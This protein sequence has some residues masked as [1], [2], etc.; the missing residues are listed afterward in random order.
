MFMIV[1]KKDGHRLGPAMDDDGTD[2]F[3]VWPT[4]EQAKV[5]FEFQME[6][7]LDNERDEW[8]IVPC[9]SPS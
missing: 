3:L 4:L 1:R 5:G 9:S 2:S 7:Y 8:E 6:S